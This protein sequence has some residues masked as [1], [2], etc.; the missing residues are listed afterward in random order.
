MHFQQELDRIAAHYTGQGYQVVLDPNAVNLPPF[1]HDFKVELVGRRAAEGVLVAV[2]K[3]REEL[4][5]DTNISR[6]A[7]ITSKQPH[8]RFDFVILEAEESG[9]RELRGAQEFSDE[10]LTKVLAEAEEMV[11]AG[12]IRPALITAWAGFE[13]AMRMRLRAAGETA[14]WGTEPRGM[15]NEL[16]SSG[17]LDTD[18][19]HQME[20]MFRLR[21]QI[22]HGFSSPS[23]D[24]TDVQF[25]NDVARQLLE[26]SQ[27]AKQHA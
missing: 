3:N 12:F 1:A 20:A 24:A 17:V 25:L 14:G 13:A 4:A 10:D 21:N 22:A 11:R 5:A 7:E 9:S 6:Y 26:D 23:F 27:S 8:W 18:E 19:F 16:Y 2:K 15:L